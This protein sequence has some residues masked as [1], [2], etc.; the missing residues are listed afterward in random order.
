MSSV[1]SL[2]SWEESASHQQL[3]CHEKLPSAGANDD[4]DSVDSLEE[5][6]D[7]RLNATVLA[8]LQGAGTLVR[9]KR[10]SRPPVTC[11]LAR[12]DESL[13]AVPET[14]AET[15]RRSE[16]VANFM[17]DTL[18]VT[19][20]AVMHEASRFEG[21]R[22]TFD[23]HV[24][25]FCEVWLQG[26]QEI[27]VNLA[28]ALRANTALALES[29]IVKLMYDET[30]GDYTV[31]TASGSADSSLNDIDSTTAKVLVVL[32]CI[33][34]LVRYR[35]SSKCTKLNLTVPTTLKAVETTTAEC[36]NQAILQ[37][38]TPI[39]P[40]LELSWGRKV[41]AVSV[42]SHSANLRRERY[43]RR[44]RKFCANFV[45]RCLNHSLNNGQGDVSWL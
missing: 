20:K 3:S 15:A 34:M 42:D 21:H 39:N 44:S 22:T 38:L 4:G 29:M 12:V 37:L 26:F 30:P 7:H 43:V 40:L 9:P 33:T 17:F 24:L 8:T 27:V 13:C 35:S 23:R 14:S 11:E 32:V 45:N 1:D 31:K 10:V 28:S 18:H 36:L 5:S 41:G 25:A 19:N 16:Q 2:D 6:G